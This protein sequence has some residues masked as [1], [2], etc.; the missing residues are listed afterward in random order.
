MISKPKYTEVIEKKDLRF[1][2]SVGWSPIKIHIDYTYMNSQ[3]NVDIK[4]VEFTKKVVEKTVEIYSTLLLVKRVNE[5]VKIDQCQEV[6]T[7]KLID[8]KIRT[9]GISSDIV[10]FPFFDLIPG[11]STEAYAG[12][13][14]LDPTTSR[15]NAGLMAFNPYNYN[16]TRRNAF[17]YYT[18]LVLHEIN[19]ILSFSEGLFEFYTDANYDFINLKNIVKNVTI[20]GLPKNMIITPKVVNAAKKHF[21]CNSLEGVEFKLL[22]WWAF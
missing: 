17:E 5:R 3:T 21:G 4:T 2:E 9:E 14:G 13:C 22:Y 16:I 19:H 10:I 8:V 18:L 15:P 20:N 12:C 11:E 6:I 7:S 1:L